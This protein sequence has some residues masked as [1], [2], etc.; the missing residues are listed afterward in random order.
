M[1]ERPEP[2]RDLDWEPQRARAFV[3]AVDIYED[4]LSRLPH[5]P[6]IGDEG[7]DQVRAGVVVDVPDEPTP[8][9]SSSTTCG[10]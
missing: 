4:L 9:L 10:A 2:V 1:A 6:V 3:D 5:L 8:R 7:L